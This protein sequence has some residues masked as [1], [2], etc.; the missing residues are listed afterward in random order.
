MP[1]E[2]IYDGYGA[3]S[4]HPFFIKN[5]I[6]IHTTH[7]GYP[8]AL[9]DS[10]YYNQLNGNGI[11]GSYGKA[12]GRV[13]S[14]FDNKHDCYSLYIHLRN[15]QVLRFMT[16]SELSRDIPEIAEAWDGNVRFSGGSLGGYQVIG[17]CALA[18]FLDQNIN[19]TLGEASVPAL[20][21]YAGTTDK[22]L[23]NTFGIQWAKYAEY[24]DAAHLATLVD[25]P[26]LITRNGLGDEVCVSSGICMA[27]NNFKG[28]KEMKFLQNSSHGYMP[29]T[30]SQL[31][32]S[33]KE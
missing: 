20:C 29:K 12:N 5:T 21:N 13:N 2:F 10:E 4:P 8:C 15:L 22:R 1:M 27:F 9:S 19:I 33:C 16:D 31:W 17:I 32:Y 3:H 23:P 7:H 25:A 26:M 11:L 14:M 18:K 28:T 24:F 30:E 6:A